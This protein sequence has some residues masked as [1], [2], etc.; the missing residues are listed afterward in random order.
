MRSWV[1]I[2]ALGLT[3][4]QPAL[5]APALP[6]AGSA[7][8][9][10]QRL[11]LGREIA[12]GFW[13]DGTMQKMMAEMSGMQ[14][15]MMKGMFD[16][17]P[18]DLGIKDAKDGDKT[19]GQAIREKDPNFEERMTITNKVMMEEMGKVMGGVEPQLREAFARVYAKRFNLTELN[20][21]AAF[22]R[23]SSGKRFGGQMVQMMADPE[24]VSTMAAMMPKIMQ[25]MPGMIEKVKKATAHLPPPP[26]D[27]DKTRP[28]SA[29]TT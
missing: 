18:K 27:D 28:A 2:S 16:Q 15:G 10:P 22:L 6:T 13:P 20:D 23:T 21:I 1:L 25:A 9:D 3:A 4:A 11:A 14:S 5:A 7:A 8:I 17:T 26:K 29:P 12:Q 24:Y 19:L